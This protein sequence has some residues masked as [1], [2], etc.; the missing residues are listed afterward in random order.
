MSLLS[1]AIWPR[2]NEFKHGGAWRALAV[3]VLNNYDIATVIQIYR[4]IGDAANVIFLENIS[5]VED[6]QI[7]AAYAAMIRSDFNTAQVYLVDT[8]L[9]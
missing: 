9:C 4:H 2:K 1:S 7:L 3:Q 6:R 8:P 5:T